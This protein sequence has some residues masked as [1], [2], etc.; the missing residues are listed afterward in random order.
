MSEQTYHRPVLLNESVQALVTDNNGLYID[1]TFGGG[2]HSRAI[3]QALAEGGRLL[4]FDQDADA[5]VNAP[6]D[7]RF[8]L[9][10]QN[11]RYLQN[12]LRLRRITTVTGVL[13]DLG[14]SSYQF[15]TPHRGFS[16]RHD[17][18]LDMR[19]AQS[20]PKT[21]ADVVNTSEE[22]H[23]K[24]VLK[25]Y[26]EVERPGRVAQHL[27][28]ARSSARIATTGQLVDVL[29]PIAPRQKENQ[30][31]AQVFQA[32][33]IEVNDEMAAL[34]DLLTQCAN[35]LQAGGRLVVISYHS[36]EDRLVKNFIKRG[37][38]NGQEEK[39]LYGRTLRPFNDVARG[40]VI[41]TPEEI[42]QNPRARSAKMRIA[43]KR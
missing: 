18:P 38:F 6:A 16:I 39:D 40:V 25:N 22:E 5:V 31:F 19:M 33:R 42:S 8:E 41:P 28:A 37:S 24:Q 29:R 13:C 4:A 34:R 35:L 7:A 10:R 14:V 11:F 3:L 21:A 2:G 17:G 23:L 26:G 30:F 20:L 27:C 12:E 9:V 1:A 15:D 32:L 36:L 43:E